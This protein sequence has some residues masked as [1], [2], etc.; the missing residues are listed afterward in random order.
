MFLRFFVALDTECHQGKI[1]KISRR[2]IFAQ[3][4]STLRRFNLFSGGPMYGVD[5]G[6]NFRMNLFIF[7]T[8]VSVVEEKCKLR[9]SQRFTMLVSFSKTVL[10]ALYFL[11]TFKGNK[12][13]NHYIINYL[14]KQSFHARSVRIYP[15]RWHGIMALRVELYG[16]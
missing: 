15:L 14:G 16:C 10:F 5:G 9:V 4:T 11:Q 2:I 6:A 12:G 8:R 13:R 7:T 3:R 1:P